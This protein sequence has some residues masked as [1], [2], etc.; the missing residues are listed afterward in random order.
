M[1]LLRWLSILFI[2]SLIA[3][4]GGGGSLDKD[5]STGGSDETEELNYVVSVQGY[6][7]STTE[8][9]N[10]VTADEPLSISAMLTNSGAV[11][12]GEVVNFSLNGD[13]G[14][15]DPVSGTVLTNADGVASITLTAGDT[16]G[17]GIITATYIN[18]EDTYSD[19]FGFTSDGSESDDSSVNGTIELDVS[20]LDSTGSPFTADNPVSKDNK[21]TVT[22]TLLEEDEPLQGQL[23]SFTTNYTGKITPVLGTALT[24][25]SGKA[26]VTLSS[27]DS[28]GAG[29]V[30]ATYTDESGNSI[31]KVAGFIS[32]GDDAPVESA[33]AELD[34]KLLR[35]CA[36]DW[37]ANRDT[38]P[39]ESTYLGS[40]CNVANQFSS[41]EL[42]DVMI[43]VTDTSSGDG[44][45]GI[46]AELSTD[47]GALL[48]ES[49]KALTDNFGF[50]I[51]KLQPGANSGAG[52]V[53]VTAKSVTASKAFEIATAE[54][55]VE[56]S[57]GLYNK[58][59]DAGNVIDNEFVPLAAG[60]TTVI[61]VSIYDSNG[62][63]FVT[64][65]DV[66]FTSAC[67]ESDLAVMDDTATSISGIATATYRSNGCNTT[68]GDTITA[69][70]LT[71]GTPKVVT[72]NVPV[73]A[74]AVSSIEFVEASENVIALKG[75]G[76]VSRKEISQLT[77]KL[78]DEIGN[79]A[80]QKRLDFRLS[81]TNGG[82][83]LSEVTDAS[84]YSH[85]S[86]S[87][88]S[89]GLARIQVNSGFV[90]Q[91][92]RVQACYIPDELIP[93]D[94]NDNV[95]CW[96]EL[97]D[98][99]LLDD[100][101]RDANVSCPTGELSLVS[102]DE[103]VITVSDL[104][105][106]SS[107]LPDSNSFTAAPT[108]FNIEALNY[109]GDIEEVNV[110]LADHFNNP[111]PDGTSVYLTT[112]GGAIGTIDGTEFNAQLECNTVDGQCVA[113]WRSQNPKPFTDAK[114]GNTISSI[115]PKT[116]ELNCDLYFGSAAPCMAGI[117]NA[118]FN[119]GGVPLG[120]RAT[121]LVTAKGQESFIDINGNG[122][123]DTNEYYSGYDLTEAFIDH[124]ENGVYDG[125][126]GIYDPVTATVIK[127]ADNCQEGDSDDPCSPEN[128]NGGHFEENLDIDLNGMHTLADGQYNGLVCK[129]EATTPTEDDTFETL[130]TKELVDIRDSFE[131][132]MSG[133]TAYSRFVVTKSE[134]RNRFAEALAETVIDDPTVF[135]DNAMQLAQDIEEC[136]NIYRQA[137]TRSGAIILSLEVTDNTDYCDVGSINITTADS[138]NQ[139]SA[140]TFAVYYSDIYNNPMPAGTSVAISADNGEY[141]GT[142][143]FDIRNSNATFAFGEALSISREADGNDKTEGFLTV[144]FTTGK[145]N[146]STAQ[147][148]ISD[149]G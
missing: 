1:P 107:G 109:T 26:S 15:L 75:T 41:D 52:E 112:E 145:G 45:D 147:I 129:A 133:S 74:A 2:S 137:D 83:S 138:G 130:C 28:K 53:S 84:G 143:G 101:E 136:N 35:G 89:E 78:T 63:F 30:I 27:G 132:I 3:A 48:P 139:L 9:A 71:G 102:L 38:T 85:A 8:E 54:L 61:S 43:K 87:T 47:L 20:I 140:L 49:G 76:G 142:D 144:E 125:L 11:V 39:L 51:L 58:L 127:A 29:Q 118:A 17:A 37:D 131:I 60:A 108:N 36:S 126:A 121:V 114:W 113:Q 134:L 86:V 100:A 22:A 119:E 12:V 40:G 10:S 44:I 5:T 124:N 128:T 149:D 122:R 111:V 59:D 67:V 69:T 104:V 65:L 92:V 16:A 25:A 19:S 91:A 18:G 4:C 90:P 116:N 7:Q 120:G 55:S 42:I 94:Q 13:I 56:I 93:A 50:A 6:S 80:K 66:E 46:I 72:V 95:T 57:N 64:P 62:D 98:E 146:I 88:D 99:C 23:I 141:S 24:D 68:Q 34:I 105:S 81:S 14:S 123:F 96:K 32:N 77:F 148:A 21:G 135:T 106:I 82:I 97:Y 70:V 110:Y 117:L 33:E 103:Q 31:T 79:T 73:S 115:N